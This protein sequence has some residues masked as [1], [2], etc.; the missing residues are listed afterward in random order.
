MIQVETD[1]HAR[2]Y[3]ENLPAVMTS[4]AYAKGTVKTCGSLREIHSHGTSVV[5]DEPHA[6]SH[7]DI[8]DCSAERF[9]D[10]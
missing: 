8:S 7:P 3:I 2:T 6:H 9:A 5:F 1:T 4:R 10:A